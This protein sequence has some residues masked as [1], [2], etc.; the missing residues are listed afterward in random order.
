VAGRAA[1]IRG[2]DRK[3]LAATA[4]LAVPLAEVSAKVHKGPPKD[5]PDYELPVWAGVLPLALTPAAPLP[6]ERLD[7]ALPPP[8]HVTAWRRPPAGR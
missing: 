7:P 1:A 5:E 6:D 4:V 8:E 2:A 3:E